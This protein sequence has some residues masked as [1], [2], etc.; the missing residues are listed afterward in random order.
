MTP[1][2]D[3]LGFILRCLKARRVLWTYHVNMRLKEKSIARETILRAAG[4]FEII[5]EYPSDKYLPSYLLLGSRDG[6]PIHVLFATD[7]KS[8]NVR[9]VTAY[10]PD[11]DK[12]E[13]GFRTRR[14]KR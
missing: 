6:D 7:V 4:S 2:T 1:P 3:P 8:D 10:R 5:E 14:V 13:E 9:V 11:P 12:W